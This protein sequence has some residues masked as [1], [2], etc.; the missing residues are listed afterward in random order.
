V[1]DLKAW[2][3]PPPKMR[4][5]ESKEQHGV[6]EALVSTAISS[7]DGVEAAPS[8]QEDDPATR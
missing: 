2:S 7:Q 3:A 6:P 4:S 1:Q 8:G 5:T